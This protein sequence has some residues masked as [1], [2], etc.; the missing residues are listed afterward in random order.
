MLLLNCIGD[1]QKG[2]SM[3]VVDDSLVI[4]GNDSIKDLYDFV[5]D[6]QRRAQESDNFVDWLMYTRIL[7]ELSLAI[8]SYTGN[9][10]K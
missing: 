5:S 3:S 2:N 10:E 1:M 9:R 7:V 6:R 4:V 8:T